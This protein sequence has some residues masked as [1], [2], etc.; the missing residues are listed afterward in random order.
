MPNNDIF[1]GIPSLGDDQGLQDFMNQ[2][3]LDTLGVNSTVPAALETP[4]TEPTP[5]PAP[6]EPAAQEPTLQPAPTPAPQYTSE[7][8]Q[9]I[10]ARNAQLEAAANAR[11]QAIP[12]QPNY[13][14][15]EYNA[16]QAVIIKQLID[17]G[18]PLSAIVNAVNKGSNAN[19]ANTRANAELMNRVQ[20]VEQYL[21]QQQYI[22]EETKF[23]NKMTEFGDRFGLSED[24]LVTFGNTA[25]AKGIN[26]A[27]VTDVEAVFRAI[28]PEQ[29]AIRVQRMSNA[30]SSQIFGGASTPESPRATAAK[31]EDAY[32]DQF[33]KGAMPNAYVRKH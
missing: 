28:Y 9:Q 7:Q 23:V 2:Q 3:T 1:S 30:P 14:A 22:N 21:Q 25:L 11:R 24:D 27:N 5:A 18:V 26:I 19:A 31:L 32:V 15:A 6:T 10:L 8:I 33:L 16:Q 20:A 12:A 13:G 17:K 4:A 29:Y